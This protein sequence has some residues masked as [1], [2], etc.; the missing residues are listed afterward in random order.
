MARKADAKHTPKRKRQPQRAAVERDQDEASKPVRS[1][2]PSSPLAKRMR[3]DQE[4]LRLFGERHGLAEAQ[5]RMRQIGEKLGLNRIAETLRKAK[6]AP[7]KANEPTPQQRKRGRS[8]R[9]RSIPPDQIE[10]GIRILLSQDKM[11]VKAACQTLRDAGIEGEDGPLYR[12]IIKPAYGG[13]S[14]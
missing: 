1:L 4:R 3:A 5:E 7:V 11:S 10:R 14:K 12:L 13:M 9:K 8:G 2:D 6:T